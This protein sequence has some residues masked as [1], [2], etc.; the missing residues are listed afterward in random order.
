M[1]ILSD[2]PMEEQ[3][4][5]NLLIRLDQKVSD[6]QT[7]IKDLENGTYNRIT[8][9][10]KEKAESKEMEAIQ[11]S[12]NI[13]Q[14]KLNTTQEKVNKDI[15]TR[16]RYLEIKTSKYFLTIMI[17]SGIGAFMIALIIYHILQTKI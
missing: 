12:V 15:E 8:I 16:M 7:T 5:H 17:Y 4:D 10:E 11:D 1:K 2:K 6:I 14:E 3:T 9:L 13:M